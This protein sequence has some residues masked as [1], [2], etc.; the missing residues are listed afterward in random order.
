[1][2]LCTL[3]FVNIVLFNICVYSYYDLQRYVYS[4]KKNEKKNSV[5]FKRSDFKHFVSQKLT[6]EI[7]HGSLV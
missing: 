5:N 6:V 1:M 4:R 7:N 3:T 2:L